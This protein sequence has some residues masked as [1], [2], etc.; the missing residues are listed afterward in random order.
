VSLS[1]RDRVEVGLYPDRLVLAR[2]KAAQT[3]P[4]PPGDAQAPRWRAALDA[5]GAL[6]ALR[7]T[8]V[9][10]VLSSFFVR[11]TV[12]PLSEALSG[13]VE[14]LA[15]ARHCLAR[16][17]GPLAEGWTVRLSREIACG[18]EPLLVQGLRETLSARGN[19]FRALEPRLMTSFNRSRKKLGDKPGWFVDVEPG[20]ALL[21]LVADASWR[22]LRALKVGPRWEDEL[23]GLIAREACFVDAPSDCP[24][25]VHA[26]P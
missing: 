23:P 15:F 16:I 11:Y 26:F 21:A 5:L 25:V 1:W 6:E 19:R 20:L 12:V 10:V 4:V 3:F 8:E 18:V 7:R 24:R 17:H 22:S 9:T 14:R 2:G 13:A